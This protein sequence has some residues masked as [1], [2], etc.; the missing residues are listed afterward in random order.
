MGQPRRTVA[1]V[2]RTL[3]WR[4][5]FRARKKLYA[6]HAVIADY[7]SSERA[8]LIELCHTR[9]GLG[10]LTHARS[11][12]FADVVDLPAAPGTL[13]LLV[14]R[15]LGVPLREDERFAVRVHVFGS[16]GEGD[17]YLGTSI[18]LSENGMLLKAKRDVPDPPH[19]L[20]R[21][22]SYPL[23]FAP[24]TDRIRLVVAGDGLQAESR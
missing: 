15:L 24:L 8:T 23:P 3:A 12:G 1:E 2:R 20:R 22:D 19:K 18:D 7:E 9:G 11:T 17:E 13:S 6:M 14:A 5:H 21:R 4:C 10:D 16:A